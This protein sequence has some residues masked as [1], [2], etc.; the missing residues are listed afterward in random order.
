MD[1][2]SWR[3][4]DF[5][6]IFRLTAQVS[7][8]IIECPNNI[9][10]LGKFD[11]EYKSF[12]EYVTALLRA[13]QA[14][15][16][17]LAKQ[18]HG[19]NILEPDLSR[20]VMQPAGL[21]YLGEGDGIFIADSNSMQFRSALIGVTT[22][23]CVPVVLVSES[24]RAVIHAGWRGLAARILAKAAQKFASLSA[25]QLFAFIG[26]CAGPDQY[27]VKQDVLDQFR[28]QAAIASRRED[29]IYLAL[30]AT[31]A[32]Q[33]QLQCSELGIELTLSDC[34]VCTIANQSFYSYRR[35]PSSGLRNLSYVMI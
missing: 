16:L 5:D 25:K 3:R 2:A 7:G 22:A 20:E 10:F 8:S 6:G 26:P 1:S 17:Y 21:Q 27:E 24:A 15:S 19:D 13:L 33:L 32:R 23:D 34:N 29:K 12:E 31:A 4:E 28:S 18:V 35:E 30:A 14:D 9:G 11:N